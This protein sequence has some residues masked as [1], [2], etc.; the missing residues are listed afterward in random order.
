MP[1]LRWTKLSWWV[2]GL[3]LLAALAA[4]DLAAAG[5][6]V[7]AVMDEP[8][9]INGELFHGGAVTLREVSSYNPSTTLNEVW[10]GERCLGLMLANAVRDALPSSTDRIV[11]ERS[12]AGQL[13]LVGFAYRDRT[14]CAFYNFRT[15]ADGGRWSAPAQRAASGVALNPR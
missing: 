15:A 8:F 14:E 13:V 12:V 1:T 6:A 4:P 2:L 5:H 3:A 11:F 9:E 10:V 7:T